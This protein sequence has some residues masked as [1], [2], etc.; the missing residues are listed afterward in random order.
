[1]RRMGLREMRR[2]AAGCLVT[3]GLL[4]ASATS[5]SSADPGG[6][7]PNST[8]TG[9]SQ[10]SSS[11]QGG[12]APG[13]AA[14]SETLTP[15][16]TEPLSADGVAPID[17]ARPVEQANP[18]LG[19][20]PS[21][22]GVDFAA[23]A[24][25]ARQ[26]AR[27]RAADPAVQQVRA[28]ART[29]GL[30]E[31]LSY[32]ERETGSIAGGNDNLATAERIDGFG[33]GS[34]RNNQVRIGGTLA[35]SGPAVRPRLHAPE[36]NG[37]IPLAADTGIRGNAAVRIPG[38][39]GDGPHGSRGDRKGDFDWYKVVAKPGE[40]I[41]AD[42]QGSMVPA[43]I[44]ITDDRGNELGTG[45]SFGSPGF[46][47]AAA[48]YL[49]TTGGTYY[50]F[51]E[52]MS[53]WQNDPF[54][55]GSGG[56]VGEEGL[57]TLTVGSWVA[58][59]DAFL[60]RLSKGDVL[61]ATVDGQ[62]HSLSVQRLDGSYATGT[63]NND[64]SGN[65]P[66]GSP[67]PGGGLATVAFVAETDGWYALVTERGAGP[68]TLSADVYRPAPE[69]DPSSAVQKVVLDFNGATVNPATYG[70]SAG[71][72]TLGPLKSFVAKWGLP[73]TALPAL[74][75]KITATVAENLRADL[76]AKGNNPNV[77][78]EIV[79]GLKA[80]DDF[81]KPNVAKVVVGGTIK[82][83]GIETIGIAQFIDPG[84]FSQ[85]DSALVLL[86]VMSAP[87]GSSDGSL[88]TYLTP[89]SNRLDFVG[90]AIGNVVSHEI[91]H[92]IGN[93]HTDN[94]N[95]VTSLMD[96]GGTGFWRLFGT[97]PDKVGG[98]ADD[99]DTDLA[100]DTFFPAEPFVGTENT[101]NVAAW[102]FS[103]KR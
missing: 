61:G 25:K 41:V 38:Q 89:G 74:A 20:L 62:A 94:G 28:A 26:E 53:S 17:S 57:Y 65:Y 24:A 84:N 72:A 101:L 40:T 14:A 1:M 83:A 33:L 54:N 39:I 29:R 93:Y 4:T 66:P 47:N 2:V 49:S 43:I 69:S 51:V 76:I 7:R 10:P 34:G 98:T 102:A 60:V 75:D 97:G 13:S 50:I 18:Y 103:A 59:R 11:G 19:L 71:S 35:D 81:G 37:S 77:A 73:A 9:A 48:R 15:S 78:V 21:L 96:A 5:V 58:D 6:Q 63:T 91:G 100:T 45:L 70:G 79:N 55:S 27:T 16:Q 30:R 86:D 68:Y 99:G 92:L 42:L 52:G 36:D 8:A 22:R 82:Q 64:L 90:Q 12:N 87:K 32:T 85:E 31:A 95:N 56:G 23:W 44:M 80:P 67:L 88:N 3:V 46:P